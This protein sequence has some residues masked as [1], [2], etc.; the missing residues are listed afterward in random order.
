VP[1]DV[2][3]VRGRG[4]R[5]DVDQ[6]RLHSG[7]D[8]EAE[9]LLQREHV[10]GVVPGHLGRDAVSPRTPKYT[11]IPVRMRPAS[12]AIVRADEQTSDPGPLS[13]ATPRRSV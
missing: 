9:L 7:L 10:P 11:K 13:M 2:D 4:E 5:L 1:P 6:Q 12:R 3:P 8:V